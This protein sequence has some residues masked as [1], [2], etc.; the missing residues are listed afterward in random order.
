MI[1]SLLVL[2][3]LQQAAQR[4]EV[5]YEIS[6]PNAAH[7]EANVSVTYTGL[8][9]RPL[10]LRMSRSSPGRYA[11]HEFAK[12]V[13]DVKAF[14]AAGKA[15]TITRPN[16][17][18]WNVSGHTGHVRLTYTL[19][20]DRAD[21]TYSGIDRTHAHLNMPATFMFARNTF[22]RPVRV[23]FNLPNGANWKIATQLKP[24]PDPQVFTAPNLQY[25]FDSPTELS[26]Y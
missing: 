17:H 26:S 11:L 2:L 14:D 21:G 5:Q 9:A 13:Y 15:L 23:R 20:A 6:F 16:E 25:F 8:S 3:A 24:T 4:P 12:N 10:E 19:Y 18:Q 7:H 1:A 22:D